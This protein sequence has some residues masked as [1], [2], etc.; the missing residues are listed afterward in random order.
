MAESKRSSAGM[1]KLVML[2]LIVAGFFVYAI[3]SDIAE[4]NQPRHEDIGL[5]LNVATQD[6]PVI[7]STIGYLI[8]AMSLSQPFVITERTLDYGD[9]DYLTQW[10]E[11]IR[12]AGLRQD[13]VRDFR[14]KAHNSVLLPGGLGTAMGVEVSEAT[15]IVNDSGFSY[16]FTRPGFSSD[17]SL[18]LIYVEASAQMDGWGMHYLL[19]HAGSKWTVARALCGWIS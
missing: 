1:V 15:N 4:D 13:L 18:A 10:D 16:A 14:R 12:D 9:D 11:C 6:L 2:L 17:N 3:R 19:E 7:E 5:G 8:D